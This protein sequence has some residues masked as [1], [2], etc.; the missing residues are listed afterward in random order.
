MAA[1]I[2]QSSISAGSTPER[3]TAALT[4]NDDYDGDSRLLNAPR[5]A[6]PIGVL[7]ADTITASFIVIPLLYKYWLTQRF[8]T[9]V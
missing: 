7:A 9:L 2:M 3:C 6:L 8:L 1:P 5:K 4:A